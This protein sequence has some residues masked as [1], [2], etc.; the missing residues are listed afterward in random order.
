MKTINC[1]YL[2][3]ILFSFLIFTYEAG[4]T[5]PNGMRKTFIN[6]QNMIQHGSARAYYGAVAFFQ[7]PGSLFFNR[8]VLIEPRFEVHLK[9]N[10]Q[11]IDIVES[12]RENKIYGF[13]IVIS[14]YKNSISGLD[15]RVYDDDVNPENVKF[16]DIGYNN[17]VN[18]LI[19]EFD[20][21]QDVYDPDSNSFSVRYCG[22]T[23]HSYDNIASHT[24]RLNYQ[25]YDT[26]R[27]NNWD[28]R[29]IY[30]EKKLILYSGESTIIY[31]AAADL[32]SL[33]GTNIAYV[34]FTG[35]MESNRR[36]ISLVGTF[37]CEDNYQ[38]PLMPGVFSVNGNSYTLYNFEAGATIN[39]IFSFINNKNEIIPHTFGYNIWQ[40]S[41][42]VTSDCGE[43]TDSITKIS[44][45]T[46]QFLPKACT[47][48]G[49][50]TLHLSE[51]NKGNAPDLKYNVYAGPMKKI[52]LI[53]YNGKITTVPLKVESNYKYLNYGDSLSG[54][55]IF[56][57]NKQLVLEFDVTD[58]YGNPTTV[59]SPSTLFV[60][61]NVNSNGDVFTVTPKVISYTF[62]PK[63]GHYQMILTIYKIGTYHIEK[64]EY[65][66]EPI[67]FNIVP[68]EVDETKSFC[69]LNGA[70]IVKAGTDL[71]VAECT[72]GNEQKFTINSADNS[73]VDF[74]NKFC[75][76]VPY[77]YTDDNIHIQIYPCH[78]KDKSRCQQSLNQE[79]VFNSDGTIV[80]R[81]SNK[82]LNVYNNHIVQTFT[83]NGGANQ[84]WVYNK[85]DHTIK[86]GNLCLS[87]FDVLDNAYEPI[88]S[89]P[90]LGLNEIVYY[91]CYLRDSEGNE[92]TTSQLLK[93]SIY[94][95]NC[96][97]QRIEPSSKTYSTEILDRQSYYSCKYITND[98]GKFEINGYLT[99]KGTSTRTKINPKI[100]L[101][102]VRGNPDS[103]ILK[104]VL[105]LYTK[106]W[107]SIDGAEI[108]YLYDQNGQITA[109]DF[110]ESN[111]QTLIS[112]YSSYPSNFD[113]TKVK[114]VLFSTHDP[115]WK[116]GELEARIIYTDGK[117]YI[118]IFTKDK[119]PTDKL[120]KKS[121]V[122]YSLKITFEK[123][124][125]TVEKIVRLKYII[126][127]GSYKTCFH[128]LDLSKTKL[129][130]EWSL[131]FL[132]GA[133]ERK[134]AKIELQTTDTLLY[135]Y[136]IGK[137][138]IKLILDNNPTNAIQFRVVPLS[139]EGTYEVYG[140][141]VASYS[142]NLRLLI[143]ETEIR[144]VYVYSQPSLACYLE[145]KKPELFIHT[146]DE[147]KEHY[148]E[149]NGTF[150][151]GNLEF[152]FRILDKYKNV[153]IKDD[154]FSA[155][156]DIYSLQ[157]GNDLTKFNVG[158]NH[159]S[160]AFQ[161]RDKLPFETRQYTWVFFM[162]DSTCNNK[163]YITYDGM[164]RGSTPVSKE[165]S[166][167]TLLNYK[168]NVKEYAYVEVIYKDTNNQ[169]YGLQSGKLE[170]IQST[171]IV[172]GTSSDGKQVNFQ[173]DSITSNYA[174]RYK[175]LFD[176][177]GTFTITATSDGYSLKNSGSN[178]LTVVDN[179]YSL[180]HSK[181]QMI[182]DTIIEMNPN[183]KISID[184]TFE[185]PYY[186][187]YFY[188]ASGLKTTYSQDIVFTCVMT[189]EKV[190][191]TLNVEKKTDCVQFTYKN[192]NMEEFVALVKGDYKLT[193]TDKKESVEYPLYLTGDG[194]DDISNEPDY[195]IEKTEVNPTHIDG[196]AG[197]TYTINIEF[198]TA[199]TFRWNYLVDTSKFSFSNS[200]NLSGE[201]FTTKVEQGYKRGQAFV[202]VTQTVV[203]TERDNILTLKYDGKTITKTVSLTIECG[204]FSKLE[205]VSGPT[206]GNVITPPILT[207]KPVDIYGNIYTGFFTSTTR[208]HLNSLTIGQSTDDIVLVSNN[209]LENNEYL[210]VQYKST[211]STNIKVTSTYF[212]DT[213]EYRIYSGD[214]DPDTSYA[215]LKSS[216]K[217]EAGATYNIMIYPKDKYNNDVDTLCKED[218]DKFYIYYQING[219]ITKNK[220]SNCKL[221]EE[222]TESKY[223]ISNYKSIECTTTVTRAGSI[224][225]HVDYVKDEIE[226]R[227]CQ[228]IIGTGD[229]DMGNTKTFYK[230]RQVYLNISS[231]N[232]IEAKKEPLFELTFFDLYSNQLSTSVVQNLNIIATFK[233]SDIKLCVSNSGNKKL[234]N[235]CPSTNGDENPNKWN[236]LVNGD[237]YQL[238]IENKGNGKQLVYQIKITGGAN[239]GS[240][241]AIDFS[242]TSFNPEKI[243]VRAGFEGKTIMEL[244]TNQ[245]VRKNYWYENP[246]L[247]IKVE[248][249]LD[250]DTCSYNVENGDLPGRY[251]IKV[252]CTK[253]NNNNSFSVA[254]E[255]IKID[256]KV[257]VVVTPGL[258]YYLEVEEVDKFI[259]S[260]D[261]YT[262]KTNPTNDD[263]ISFNFKLKDKYQNYITTSVLNNNEI[264]VTS[265]TYETNKKYYNILFNENKKDYLF[266]DLIDVYVN[267]H[268][269]IIGCVESGR[270]YSFIYTKLAGEPDVNKSYWTIDKTAY[271]I[272]ET[273]TVL[274]TLLDKLGVNVGTV[275]GKLSTVKSKVKVD[276]YGAKNVSYAYIDITNQNNITYT[277]PYQVLGKYE[278][279]VYYDGK[280]IKKGVPITV[281]Y[282]EVDLQSSKLFYDNG[283]SLETLM[284]TSE[285]TYINNLKD[286]PFY[287]FYLYTSSKEKIT[288]YDH[289]LEATCKM[290]YKDL[291]W[292]LD[293]TKMDSYLKLS[294]KEGF[295]PTFIKLP[296][297]NYKL[298]IT[299]NKKEINYPLYLLGEK[300]VSPLPNYDLSKTYIKPNLIEGTAG[301]QY[302]VEIEFRG[303]D[304]LR[305]NY[306][307]IFDSFTVTDSYSLTSEQLKIVKQKGGKNGQMKLLITQYVATTGKENNILTMTYKSETIPQTIKLSIKCA[308]LA[309]LE[310]D[311]GAEDGTV[312]NP[313]IVKFTP[314]DSYDNLCTDLF[315]EKL[316]PKK[317]LEKLTTGV[318][319]EK[320]PLTTNSYVSKGQF[321][322]VQYGCTK[323]TTI[324]VTARNNPKTYQYKL[325]SGPMEAK[326]SIAQVEN[327]KNVIAGQITIINIYPKDIYGNSVTQ[328]MTIDDLNKI[329]VEY[330]VNKNNKA[331]INKTCI[332]TKDNIFKCSDT[333]TKTGEVLFDVEYGQKDIP[334]SNCKFNINP[335]KIDFSKTKVYNKN[336]NNEMSTTTLNTLPSSTTPKFELFF[337]D[338][339]NNAI[340]SKTDVSALTV[341]TEFVVTDVKLCVT[342]NGLTKLST[343]C[344]SA[345]NDENEEKWKYL[346]NGD[347]Y[348]LIV[349]GSKNDKSLEFPV[350]VTGGYTDG[351][352]AP[353]DLSKTFLNPAILTLIAGE[354]QSILLELRTKSDIRKNYWFTELNK[355]ISIKFPD[356]VNKCQYSIEKAQKP[357]Q[358]SIIFGCTEKKDAF[359]PTIL[360]ENAELPKKL[361]ITVNPNVPA[362]SRLFKMTG[363]EIKEPNL[364]SVSV[365]DKFQMKTILYDKYNNLITAVKSYLKSLQIEIKPN[366]NVPAHKSSA[367]T[368]ED[369]DGVIIISL[370]S[371]YAGKHTVVGAY[372]PQNYNIQFTHGV[373]DDNSLLEVSHTERI[374]GEDV[375]IYITPY[376]QYN[377]YIDAIELKD[378][379]PYQTKYTNE[380]SNNELLMGKYSVEKYN[381]KNVLSYP[382][383]FYVRGIA[384]IFGY[385]GGK[386]IKCVTCRIN[387]K[388]KDVYFP[389]SDVLRFVSSKKDFETLKNGAVEKNVQEE[390]VYRLYPR[391]Q[392][393]NIVDV[394]PQATLLT[395]K[396]Y[397]ASQ[398]EST[399][400]HLKLNNNQTVNQSYA[401]FVINDIEGAHVTYETLVGGYYDLVFTNGKDKLVYNITLL[402]D[403][404]GGSNEAADIQ[405][406]AI[407]EQNLKYLA[408]KTGYMIVEIRTKRDIRKNFWDGFNIRVES[409]DANDK[410]F[411]YTQEHGGLLGVFLITVKTE[412]A[413]T[414]PKLS[415]CQLKIYV[416][417]ELVKKLSPEQE[418]SPNAV[419]RTKILENYYKDGKSSAILKDGTADK[420]YEFEVASYD[421]YNNLAETLQE[422]V[423]IKVKYEGKE[424]ISKTNS[425]TEIS[426]GYRKYVVP[427]TK[428][429]NYVINTEKSGSQ[430]LYLLNESTFK[431]HPG[432]IDLS[433]TVVNEKLTPI[434]AGEKP[435][436][437]IKAFDKYGNALY[438]DDYIMKFTSIFIDANKISHT[439]K[440]Q[441]ENEMD[442][443]YSSETPV[444]IVG[445]VNVEVTYDKKNKIDTSD[446]DIEVIPA[447][448][449]APNSILLRETSEGVYTKYKNGSSFQIDTKETLSLNVTLYDKYN[450]LITDIP[451]DSEILKPL[452][453]GNYM[454]E[455]IFNV[456][457]NTKYFNLDFNENHEYTH[458]YQHLV[459]GTYDLTYTVKT[460]LGEASFKYN[461]VIPGGDGKHGN[462]RYVIGKCVITPQKI[463]FMAGTY[464]EFSLELR[465][466]QGLLYNDDINTTSD[467]DI[468]NVEKDPTFVSTVEK[469]DPDYYGVYT[470]KIYSEKKGDRSI[471]A[472]LADITIKERTKKRVGP[473]YYNVYPE[474]VPDRRFTVFTIP[475]EP[476][477]NYNSMYEMQFILADKFNNS[478][479]GRNDIVDDKYLTLLNN[480]EPLP[481]ASLTLSP[482][483][484][485]YKLS[486]YPK[487]PPKTMSMNILYND[488]EDTVYCFLNNTIVT[489]MVGIDY[490]LT[491]IVSSNKEKIKAGEKLDMWL[492][493][494][495]KKGE[496][497]DDQNYSQYYE[498]EVTGPMDSTKQSTKKYSVKNIVKKELECNNE[499]QIIT[500]DDDKYK[501]A[502]NYIIKVYGESKDPIASYNQVCLPLGYSLNGF[503]LDYTFDPNKI[504]ILDKVSFTVTGTDMYGNK[505]T[506][507]LINDLE[508]YFTKDGIKTPFQRTKKEVISGTLNFED[509]AIHVVGPHQLH[510]TY[511]EQEV[512][513]VNHGEKLPIFTILVGPCRAENN[514]HFDF[515]PLNYTKIHKKTHFDFQCYD[516]YN[517]KITE[518]GEKF[519]VNAIRNQVGDQISVDA[520]V[521]DNLDGTYSVYF[522]PDIEG[523][524]LFNLL[525][526]SEKYGEEVKY[527]FTKKV[528]NG[529][530]SILCP[531]TQECVKDYID[532]VEP[533]DK[534]KEDKTK[535]FW[536]LVNGTYTCT[537]S[538]VDCD[539]PKG[540]IKCKIQNYCVPENRPDMCTSYST[541]F[542]PPGTVKYEDG[543]CR[544]KDSR[545]PNQRVCPIGKVL[546]ADLS[547]RD[548]YDECVVTEVRPSN[549][550]RC[551]GQHLKNSFLLCPS[552][553]TCKNENEVVCPDLEC[554]ENE[555]MCK[556]IE[557]QCNADDKPYLCQ[558]LVCAADYKNCPETMA[559]G[560]IQSLCQDGIC[561]ETC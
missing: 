479:E 438:P 457:E 358:Y 518:G 172:K 520:E 57:N 327:T 331:N 413:N 525:V 540:Y 145:F 105:N 138:N 103:Y 326:T 157:F 237:K 153:I 206:K 249:A 158:Y 152:F 58:Q 229:T 185:R 80:S 319:V 204:D 114:A 162:R 557:V 218:M 551:V 69:T 489:I 412:K 301:K 272:E 307:I 465:N 257:L 244:R 59:S 329:N 159:P 88:T 3:L 333:I 1:F 42:S 297:G 427:A 364:G 155:Y 343:V 372:F 181:L 395:Y 443:F 166:F 82:C 226:C 74:V 134:F 222:K 375:K 92:I 387:I 210:K 250:K 284:L 120:V 383:V 228:L 536:C 515:T 89:A 35:F 269:W 462:G 132:I 118:G 240:S 271:T 318:S 281:S 546:C 49:P 294:Y 239:D 338:K 31:N 183:K 469:A 100:N 543:F 289:S 188:T 482:D 165:K 87:P 177:F 67:R 78:L 552:T 9:A 504:S 337:F 52:V 253:V 236:Y 6:D 528:C 83:C 211:I 283:D 8:Q 400:Y 121:S 497:I 148:Y 4:D 175:Y 426:T 23:C 439:S 421:K 487:Y 32:E 531:N 242:K 378:K 317:E 124:K 235:L 330:E 179:I 171:T 506:D 459:G 111:G 411:N 150:V 221:I 441:K 494:F 332:I 537:K 556:G 276:S 168:I 135:N 227:N 62:Q 352:S 553:F 389:K 335:D 353:I 207:F 368:L 559:C 293:V 264:T 313:S 106:K 404:K 5:C 496:C 243:E 176:I 29:L 248:F 406:T 97:N 302:S 362:S 417:N 455:I 147:F 169:F 451:A 99:K 270:K 530:K 54:D 415:K 430:G 416:N 189:G 219:E 255:S 79:F 195:V 128:N 98:V 394:I 184:N 146:G 399:V 16:A 470:I 367:Q 300:D 154:Y 53:G 190:S 538:Q 450:N 212:K 509:V 113:V 27:E 434:K 45:Y 133:S 476:K 336:G 388:S 126:N 90:T 287:K 84:K 68:G 321:L 484:Q 76:D 507:S 55:F 342:N 502:G 558:N 456:T 101:F 420:N 550:F 429:G 142:G 466:A 499:Y 541:Q 180:K 505:V 208:E 402:G 349:N 360:V 324:K 10:T 322:N 40:Y 477:V 347:K 320:Y 262:W 325:W 17:F 81:S 137:E 379:N 125:E 391:D 315:D 160:E 323:I 104:N 14:G 501:Y 265:E 311:S 279:H 115:N 263:E 290:T 266:K 56:K 478:F 199:N 334:C 38:I 393:E 25:R 437:N 72:G 521:E 288:H 512:L 247:K 223:E 397:L 22:K 481:Y 316:Y 340:T 48:A 144:K 233:G 136:D 545:M 472:L 532:C 407:V 220:V 490:S 217:I 110:A 18:S 213:Y 303:S 224:E 86:N 539:C 374:A 21:E 299:F 516:I 70:P 561:R 492:Y 376:D 384:S 186:R 483:K 453:S 77:C 216:G 273:S 267:K 341:T 348:K 309:L 41:F 7:F 423:G 458:I 396:A 498:I 308:E 534:C 258:A 201:K 161:F 442:V 26:T 256:K 432:A 182:K 542:C 345:N 365:D 285:D 71:F 390:P 446:A 488:G 435:S 428:S 527:T 205:Y 449:Y 291:S 354:S 193:I 314:K 107:L 549:K 139:I 480:E 232:E 363:E 359:S 278:V 39:Y 241:D 91:V 214:I 198:R 156:A 419:V 252:K 555:I 164:R 47:K 246:S 127:I 535:P 414:Y 461:M 373:P 431:I 61:K 11:A 13:T 123:S 424:E 94:N 194:S 371:T 392:Y 452:M 357:G 328:K 292:D 366:E 73:I 533:A 85:D 410:T 151:D 433:K 66:S 140:K 409:C 93:N 310:Y 454:E 369:K 405:K 174:I 122:D 385:I 28:F 460:S 408:G 554:V 519:T 261:K 63:D 346:T 560:N 231:V 524:Y 523:T 298:N 192:D 209:Y 234:I 382:G 526:G 130:M 43:T 448:P 403:G 522:I 197:K 377:N 37:I 141:A 238:I 200:Y 34:G 495:D 202:Y 275:T 215:E 447:E 280:E 361:S 51:K 116:F 60:L 282:Q 474:K 2:L 286:Y 351:D 468:E 95:F 529:E 305:W 517:N 149:Y 548:N 251:I 109:L 245:N 473:G 50:H 274:V 295:K 20:F 254:V 178:V 230:N 129:D 260:V 33:L 344:K 436:I 19:I 513:T 380:G 508:I 259:V 547:C 491:Q 196:V 381:G 170:K 486:V 464:G 191:M 44:N 503:S 422:V 445:N 167:Y 108:T 12:Q 277:Y 467:I 131:E 386:G 46:L 463:S 350:K 30:V 268:T 24:S 306:D 304:N 117:P 485:T 296:L 500:T 401:E 225:F 64:N 514:D 65:M 471:Y 510:M 187:L 356:N 203:T 370:I 493:T 339:Y 418:V 112:S 398:N 511:K 143:K 15:C 355:H 173:F 36:E 312:V 444:T 163:Y 440:G 475:P 544:S 75:L 425:V 119:L 102:Y 96:E